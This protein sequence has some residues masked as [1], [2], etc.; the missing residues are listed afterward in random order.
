MRRIL[1]V[2]A[3]AAFAIYANAQIGAYVL[4]NVGEYTNIRNAPRGKVVKR[5]TREYSYMIMMRVRNVR[6]GWWEIVPNTLVTADDGMMVN[7]D[8]VE[9]PCYI[10]YSVIALDTR[11]YGGQR[12][13]LRK[14]PSKDGA[15]TFS[16]LDEISVRPIGVRGGWVKV[17]TTDR[18]HTGWIEYKWLCPNPLTD[19]N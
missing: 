10:H 4:D 17:Q 19:C 9:G 2:L 5:L 14:S 12:L 18:K 16:F 11:N 6:D 1:S 7:L 13:C 15:V 3:M 8:N